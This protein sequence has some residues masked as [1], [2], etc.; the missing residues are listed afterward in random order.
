MIISIKDDE[1]AFNPES[2]N[3]WSTRS[4]QIEEFLPAHRGVRFSNGH[5]EHDID[6]V[7]FCTGYHYIFPFLKQPDNP[8]FVPSGA[9]ADHL[10]HHMLYTK[11]PTLAFLCIPQQIA[12]FPFGEGQAAVI[13]RMWSGRLETPSTEEMDQWVDNL[14]AAKGDAKARH[15]L[16]TPGNIAYTNMFYDMC[17]KATPRPELGLEN[18]GVG[19][20][21][22]YW[23]EEMS[24]IRLMTLNIKLA[25]RALGERRREVTTLKQLGFDFETWKSQQR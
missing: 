10:W 16:G 5:V 14:R 15:L 25:M 21:P 7:I 13:A 1:Y 12:P 11:D 2:S 17:S 18:H 3:S 6:S 23:D 4:P 19:K 20:L 24:W 8:V 9:Y 22:I